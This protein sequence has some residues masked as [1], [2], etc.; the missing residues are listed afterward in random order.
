MKGSSKDSLLGISHAVGIISLFKGEGSSNKIFWGN[1]FM[2]EAKEHIEIFLSA[3]WDIIAGSPGIKAVRLIL[4]L[5]NEDMTFI[6]KLSVSLGITFT[7]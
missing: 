4:E 1:D 7:K 2:F 6:S 5:I 3:P